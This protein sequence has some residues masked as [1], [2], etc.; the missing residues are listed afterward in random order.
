MDK[1]ESLRIE[2]ENRITAKLKE[3]TIREGPKD[4]VYIR[5]DM[6]DDFFD[7]C[8]SLVEY[9]QQYPD[10]VMDVEIARVYVVLTRYFLQLTQRNTQPEIKEQAQRWL[11]EMEGWM[12]D[13]IAAAARNWANLHPKD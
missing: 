4:R 6:M 11:D 5:F 3:I 12:D 10:T 9:F 2:I 8:Q 1:N 7:E 13:I